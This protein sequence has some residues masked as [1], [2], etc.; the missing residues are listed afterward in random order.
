MKTIAQR[1]IQSLTN[2]AED[3]EREN[4]M[5]MDIRTEFYLSIP[6]ECEYDCLAETHKE[7]DGKWTAYA[8][9]LPTCTSYGETKQDALEKL[10]EAFEELIEDSVENS[11]HLN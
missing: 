8:A 1:I 2:L 4:D 9:N 7:K 3:L 6:C 10:R 5:N 11:K